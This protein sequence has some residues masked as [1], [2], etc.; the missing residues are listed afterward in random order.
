MRSVTWCQA[1]LAESGTATTVD[2]VDEAMEASISF[3]G[4]QRPRPVA[5]HNALQL[6]E[7]DYTHL[8][9]NSDF[10]FTGEQSAHKRCEV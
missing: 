10:R 4:L 3:V 2:T 6:T 7:I 1:R 9:G 5:Q 8:M